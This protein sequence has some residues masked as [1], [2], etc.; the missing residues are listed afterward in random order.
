MVYEG[1]CIEMRVQMFF[2]LYVQ[3]PYMDRHSPTYYN[4]ESEASE[5]I[6]ARD[7]GWIL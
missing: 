5:G 7:T 2:G 3:L 4:V 6:L 1:K